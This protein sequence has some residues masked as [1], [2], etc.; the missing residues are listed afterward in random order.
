MLGGGGL[1]P[2]PFAELTPK[3]NEPFPGFHKSIIS[4]CSS[5]K[6]NNNNYIKERFFKF[7]IYLP[8]L[9]SMVTFKFPSYFS[10]LTSLFYIIYLIIFLIF[11][12]E[13][14]LL[15]VFPFA[16]HFGLFFLTQF[17]FSCTIFGT[18]VHS[19]NITYVMF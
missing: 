13:F 1:L 8:G 19:M 5:H 7:S 16:F 14:Y 4:L 12:Q 10:H 15:K 9:N 3:S 11:L 6:T 17:F 2:L 18:N